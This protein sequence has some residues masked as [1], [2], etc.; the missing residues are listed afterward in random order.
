MGFPVDTSS[1][2]CRAV[3]R[4]LRG[5]YNAHHPIKRD[6]ASAQK[7]ARAAI[8]KDLAFWSCVRF[9][10]ELR[11]PFANGLGIA[12]VHPRGSQILSLDGFV[13]LLA[14]DRNFRGSINSQPDFV[15]TDIDDRN[16]NVVANHDAFVALSRQNEHR[17][18]LP[19]T[20][21][22]WGDRWLE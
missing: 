2:R 15:A 10:R 22:D 13:N 5:S 4:R 8:A 19:S 6:A 7:A 3:Q 21:S 17:G 12:G 14:M 20:A 9:G 16:D 1:A 11:H 18:L